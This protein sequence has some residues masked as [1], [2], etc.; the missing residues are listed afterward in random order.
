MDSP[1]HTAL[2]KYTARRRLISS[3]DEGSGRQDEVITPSECSARP[4]GSS[5]SSKRNKKAVGTPS[6]DRQT[7]K[8]VQTV[9]THSSPRSSSPQQEP[10]PPS[11]GVE[12]VKA[13]T[14]A[15]TTPPTSIEES[16]VF[17][18]MVYTDAMA[19]DSEIDGMESDTSTLDYKR[20]EHHPV[21]NPE[22]DTMQESPSV[23]KQRRLEKQIIE[24]IKCESAV[25]PKQKLRP[26][27][28]QVLADA[29]M[30]NWLTGHDNICILDYHADR[31][32]KH[33][34]SAL[35]AESVRI[36]CNM[37][38]LYLEGS[39]QF[40]DVN[41]LKNNLQTMCKAIRQHQKG[42]GIFI[43]NILPRVHNSPLHRPLSEINFVLL[44][45]VCCVNRVL[46]KIHYLS[47]YEHFVSKKDNRIIKP[48]HQ[49]FQEN[50]QLTR[51][52]C[53]ILRECFLREAGLKTYWF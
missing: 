21:R 4:T 18:N 36:S 33:W 23:S 48:T 47:A 30:A 2:L 45:A 37:V 31:T 20:G 17:I 38:I 42:A 1:L 50:G 22:S 46:G 24:E 53:M 32:F 44:Q 51:Y 7:A 25:I 27:S 10:A 39:Q 13:G 29:K 5:S 43:S 52:G 6:T 11:P 40:V 15:I 49:F 28:M 19:W 35:R 9:R 14:S 16:E 41:P 3:E 12:T 34:I 26:P 8:T